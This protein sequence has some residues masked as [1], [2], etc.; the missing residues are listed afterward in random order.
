MILFFNKILNT[1]VIIINGKFHSFFCLKSKINGDL[2]MLSVKP[3]KSRAGFAS[4]TSPDFSQSFSS[5]GS[6]RP[7]RTS[8]LKALN[9]VSFDPID[10][11]PGSPSGSATLT[12]ARPDRILSSRK[13]ESR[14]VNLKDFVT[15]RKRVA[16]PRHESQQDSLSFY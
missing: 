11:S 4:P 16:A 13:D 12:R 1:F 3:R 10:F 9:C 7:K 5:L 6:R 14:R 2:K 15:H 8:G